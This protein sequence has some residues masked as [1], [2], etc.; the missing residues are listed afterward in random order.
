MC[1]YSFY[2]VDS[3]LAMLLRVGAL[4]KCCSC[5][6]V[7]A[8]IGRMPEAKGGAGETKEARDAREHQQEVDGLAKMVVERMHGRS[9]LPRPG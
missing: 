4:S 7:R 2:Q 6:C 1:L 9:A 8:C 5:A 3:V